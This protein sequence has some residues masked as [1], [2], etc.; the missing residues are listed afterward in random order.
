MTT[1]DRHSPFSPD[2]ATERAAAELLAA[3][4]DAAAADLAVPPALAARITAA[5]EAAVRAGGTRSASDAPDA[6]SAP[7]APEAAPP[8]R[9]VPGAAASPRRMLVPWLVAVAAS[10]A[11]LL[12]PSPLRRGAAAPAATPVAALRDSLA[13]LARVQRVAWAASTDPAGRAASG[14]VLWDAVAQRGVMRFVGL[15]P[16]DPRV[17]QYQLWIVDA[18]RDAR[19]PVDGGVFDVTS[20]GEVLVPISA[21]VP[22][23]RATLF[24]VTLEVPGGVVVSTRER[25]VLAAPV[26][27]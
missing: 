2:D 24:A 11:W 15:V 13:G 7:T 10:L 18:E 23:A 4:G 1:R 19:Y 12:L 22:V 17:A 9:A 27:G 14:E 8:L 6:P 20:S 25:L 3:L 26:E 5:G 16:N 21:R